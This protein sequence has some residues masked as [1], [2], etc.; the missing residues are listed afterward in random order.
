MKTGT[1]YQRYDD[2]LYFAKLWHSFNLGKHKEPGGYKT[3]FFQSKVEY[4]KKDFQEI[5]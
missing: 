3:G 1:V 5:F 4:F 2:V